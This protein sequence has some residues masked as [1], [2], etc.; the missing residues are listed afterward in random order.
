MGVDVLAGLAS[1]AAPLGGRAPEIL[2]VDSGV[3]ALTVAAAVQRT[4]PEARLILAA[5]NAAFPYGA[6]D[7]ATLVDRVCRVVDALVQRHSPDLVIVACNTASTLALPLL[8][9]HVSIP[10]VGTVPAVKTAAERSSSR[11]IAVLATPGTIRRAYT[12]D[13]VA[14]FAGACEVTLVGASRL[15]GLC[16]AVLRGEQVDDAAIAAEIAPCFT[17]AA[18]RRTDMVVLACT[19]FPLIVDRL[20][21]AAP[22]PVTFIDPAAAIARRASSLLVAAPSGLRFPAPAAEAEAETHRQ[23]HRAVFTSEKNLPA[24]LLAAL[25]IRG[26]ADVAVEPIA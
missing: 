2:L 10:V 9:Q 24:A 22:W 20:E 4:S 23:A 1:R 18:G 21:R 26:F 15:A 12:A 3:G 13:L 16:E 7:D 19:H 25:A 5:D 8:R 14:T 17:Q 6:L 11:R